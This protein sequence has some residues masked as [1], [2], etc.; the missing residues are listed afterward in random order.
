[1]NEF[2][3]WVRQNLIDR[4]EPVADLVARLAAEFA[5]LVPGDGWRRRLAAIEAG[6][7]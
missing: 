4:V 5:A 7:A 6:W 1:M 3:E 2:M